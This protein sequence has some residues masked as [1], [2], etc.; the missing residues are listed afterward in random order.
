[1]LRKSIIGPLVG[2]A[3]VFACCAFM[4]TA[5]AVFAHRAYAA[6]SI[7][8]P[9][10]DHL[11]STAVVADSG[12]NIV[13]ENDYFPFGE[14]RVEESSPQGLDDHKY[15]GQ[16]KDEEIGLY[17]YNARY[18]HSDL[19]R[20]VSADPVDG[21]LTAPQSLNKHSYTVNNPIKYIDP[22]GLYKVETGEIEKGDT[23]S[24]IVKTINGAYGIKTDWATIAD[25]SFF[26]DKYGTT[27]VTDL[28]GRRTNLGT[29]KANVVD[30]TARLD[31]Y[32]Q[33]RASIIKALPSPVINKEALAILFAP[34]SLWDLKNSSDEVLGSK[35]GRTHWAYIYDDKL[36]RYDAPG[37]INFGYVAPASGLSKLSVFLGAAIAQVADG[38]VHGKGI[39]SVLSGDNS[40]D[41]KYIN[42]GYD[43]YN[44]QSLP[45][46]VVPMP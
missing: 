12:G 38:L 14:S 22:S 8:Y 34:H 37:N 4:V 13:A 5:G 28:V 25:V 42:I 2:A 23:E 15:T 39:S 36:I 35:G 21:D 11:G 30:I 31:T 9:L 19:G 29:K 3:R 44:N 33:R 27:G 46:G 24:L 1:M 41:W 32:N 40:G 18:Y 7:Y 26:Q 10:T 43:R 45:R 6:E 20:F 17:Y 16:E